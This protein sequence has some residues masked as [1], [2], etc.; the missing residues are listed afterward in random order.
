MNE[1]VRTAIVVPMTSKPKHFPF[2]VAVGFGGIRGELLTDH[3]R[4]LDKSRLIRKLG[5]LDPLTSET[6]ASKLVD[7]FEG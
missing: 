2:R 4:S 5:R 7:I 3:I 6:L 1:R